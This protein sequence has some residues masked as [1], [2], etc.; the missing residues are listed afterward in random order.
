M[1]LTLLDIYH[2]FDV[3]FVISITTFNKAPTTH[4]LRCVLIK[5]LIQMLL[6]LISS[7]LDQL[8]LSVLSFLISIILDFTFIYKDVNLNFK[9]R[10]L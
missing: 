6:V 9:S 1:R 5:V 7:I 3:S 2:E 4:E 8:S 10:K